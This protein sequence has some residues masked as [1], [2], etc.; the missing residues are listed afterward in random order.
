MQLNEEKIWQ[1][2]DNQLV[3]KELQQIERLIEVSPVW[4]DAYREALHLQHQLQQMDGAAPSMRFTQNV[5]D[6]LPVKYGRV[7]GKNLLGKWKLRWWVAASLVTPLVLIA[8]I[9]LVSTGTET[10]TNYSDSLNAL[11]F[12]VSFTIVGL[13]A[14]CVVLLAGFDRWLNH[15]FL[16]KR[17]K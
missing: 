4:R 3:G 12:A 11:F 17:V 6:N 5:M 10:T 9:S 15:Y 1:Y 14:G 16:N 2:I 7:K 8:L 13:I